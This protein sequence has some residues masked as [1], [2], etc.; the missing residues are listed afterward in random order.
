MIA[1]YGAWV[2]IGVGGAAISLAI[3]LAWS[4]CVRLIDRIR[5]GR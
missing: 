1:A 4:V 5:E 3:A 2:L